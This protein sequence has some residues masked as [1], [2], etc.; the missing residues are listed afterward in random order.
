MNVYETYVDIKATAFFCRR[1][2]ASIM[3]VRARREG[4][5]FSIIQNKNQTHL[6]RMKPNEIF[7]QTEK[8]KSFISSETFCFTQDTTFCFD[9]KKGYF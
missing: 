4:D 9:F 7:W 1:E 6:F 5:N 2:L 3:H 8:L